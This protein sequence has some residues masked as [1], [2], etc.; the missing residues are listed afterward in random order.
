[1]GVEMMAGMLLAIGG[2]LVKAHGI[3]KRRLKEIVVADGQAAHQFRELISFAIAELREVLDVPPAQD[4]GLEGP[5]RPVR[6]QRGEIVVGANNSFVA[7]QLQL[8]IAAQKTRTV[9]LAVFAQR[10]HLARRNIRQTRRRPRS[11]SVGADCSRPSARRDSRKSARGVSR[12]ARPVPGIAPPR[13]Q[14]RAG[15]RQR[16]CAEWSDRGAA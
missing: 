9:P 12:G 3:G 6:H 10:F 5:Y 7:R 15:F 2:A 8:E 4:H 1:M 14:S 11:G 16:S 13:R